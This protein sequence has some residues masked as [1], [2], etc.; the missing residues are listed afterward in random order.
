MVELMKFTNVVLHWDVSF[1]RVA[2]DWE[3]EVVSSFMDT[4]YVFPVRGIG[5]D[6]MSW[7][8][9]RN[10][11]FMVSAYYCLFVGSNDFSF[12]WKS[13]WKQKIHS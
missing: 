7:K 2:N 12:P 11:G 10:K 13:I 6:E 4:I 9:D 3:L 5:E 8:L 1:F